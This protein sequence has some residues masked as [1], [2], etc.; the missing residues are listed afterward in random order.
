MQ[1]KA[2]FILL[3]AMLVPFISSLAALKRPTVLSKSLSH[4]GIERTY[5]LHLPPASD[6][7]SLLPLII[8]L[9]GGHGT[10]KGMIGLTCGEF[11]RLAD[12]E[13]F[14]V[15][16]LYGVGH[17]WNDG[18][19]NLPDSYK[20][21]KQNI[22][23]VGFISALID[24]LVRTHHVD[25]HKIYVTGMS[26][27]AMM[28]QRLAIELSDRIAA[29]APVC[30]SIPIA[31]TS[32]PKQKVP[33]LIING[34]EDPLVPYNGGQVHFRKRA[35]GKIMSVN[36]SLEFWL[37]HNQNTSTPIKTPIPDLDPDDHCTATIVSYGSPTD[38]NQVTLITIHNGGHTWPD[39]LHY[40]PRNFIGYTCNDFNACRTIWDFF[41]NHSK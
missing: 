20:A 19:T 18:R 13:H 5:L 39:G 16:Y 3:L 7:K 31:L 26:N 35:F 12:K 14:A 9:H 11:N 30:G 27:G 25:P 23:D 28:A 4:D 10:G 40:L 22:D 32:V 34:T 41:K 21:H 6:N 8:V 38:P 37:Q 24:E 33:I 2:P 17:N 15:A 36:Q 1:S 29:A